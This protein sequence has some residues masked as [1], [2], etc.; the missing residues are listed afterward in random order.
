MKRIILLLSVIMITSLNLWSNTWFKTNYIDMFGDTAKETHFTLSTSP[1]GVFNT[2][3]VKDGE[4]YLLFMI[5]NHNIVTFD[6]YQY[7]NTKVVSYEGDNI[8]LNV[9]VGDTI[10]EFK[11]EYLQ[12]RFCLTGENRV[13]FNTLMS[14]R[15]K[16]TPKHILIN[17]NSDTYLF[18]GI[19]ATNSLNTL[20]HNK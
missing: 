20:I 19:I 5:E 12:D 13:L 3:S 7:G 6:I 14:G 15:Y 4:A 9:K 11:I 18:S 1:K 10:E 16:A 2:A 17:I 8:T